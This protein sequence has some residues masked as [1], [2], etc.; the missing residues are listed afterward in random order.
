MVGDS[1]DNILFVAFSVEVRLE[2][3][4]AGDKGLEVREDDVLIIVDQCVCKILFAPIY[5]VESIFLSD[6]G[7]DPCNRHG[8][9]TSCQLGGIIEVKDY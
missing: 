1:E 5:H 2:G 4:I 9:G 6:R 7:A 8:I 3:D